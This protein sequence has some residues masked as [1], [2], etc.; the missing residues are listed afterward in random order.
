MRRSL[1]CALAGLLAGLLLVTTSACSSGG[2]S[3][4]KPQAPPPPPAAP[5]PPA[6]STPT[7]GGYHGV[8]PG[9][10]YAVRSTRGIPF[11]AALVDS[12][13]PHTVDVL[14][15]LFEPDL[16][17]VEARMPAV[18]LIHGGGFTAGSRNHP[19]MQ[20]FGEEFARQGYVAVAI[21]YRLRPA[22]PVLS[23]QFQRALDN[24]RVSP[25]AE[26]FVTAQLAALEDTAQAIRWI[27]DLAAANGFEISGVALLGP[28]AGAVT[29]INF[30][31]AL[32][33]LGVIVPEIDAV[34]GLWG[35]IGLSN[36]AGTS[37][38]TVDEAPIIMV[39]GTADTIVSY[40][41]GSLPIANRAA[42][43]GLPYELYANIG[44]GHSFSENEIFDLE[45]FPNS[46]VSQA[47]RIMD[48]VNVAL[49]V[50]DCLRLQGVI[51]GCDLPGQ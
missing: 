13:N 36:G 32:D 26:P 24:M 47:R 8:D 45:T 44:A 9:G 21:D 3:G 35:A 1:Q 42:S 12:G 40:E 43:I 16:D 25:S 31:Y 50:P 18:V 2:S 38:I 23:G 7:P 19:K 4:E 29:A 39:H 15:D 34:V 22:D 37:V 5:A 20:R 41:G 48:F 10:S 11:T 33:N 28:S 27:N 46:G 14:L 17:L 49:L 30:A 6:P 51:D